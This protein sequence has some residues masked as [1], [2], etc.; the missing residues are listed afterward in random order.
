MQVQARKELCGQLQPRSCDASSIV[1]QVSALPS[2][3][4]LPV[5]TK[6]TVRATPCPQLKTS[7]AHPSLPEHPTDP[8]V[9]SAGSR[10]GRMRECTSVERP[11]RKPC[12]HQVDQRRRISTLFTQP[13]TQPLQICCCWAAAKRGWSP[14]CLRCSGAGRSESCRSVSCSVDLLSSRASDGVKPAGRWAQALRPALCTSPRVHS[15]SSSSLSPPL[16]PP[17][18]FSSR[19]STVVA[20][21][22]YPSPTSHLYPISSKWSPWMPARRVASGSTGPTS[23][24]ELR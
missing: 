1:W 8:P 15:L 18:P 16:S 17:P 23:P 21:R 6:S 19:R 13:S 11:A 20:A 2:P 3:A 9:A 10:R 4:D 7:S 14:S 12:M 24:S 5:P 22:A